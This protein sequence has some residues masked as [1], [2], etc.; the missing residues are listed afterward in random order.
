MTIDD[1]IAHLGADHILRI[2]NSG[3]ARDLGR[4]DSFDGRATGAWIAHDLTARVAYL[5][6]AA[7]YEPDVR[8]ACKS[9]ERLE[10]EFLEDG[11]GRAYAEMVRRG[12]P[13]PQSAVLQ[14]AW[15]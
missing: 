8:Q 10:R 15:L 4:T 13:L 7:A 12:I 2:L 14:P 5:T 9:P 1:A 6:L 11:S 3:H